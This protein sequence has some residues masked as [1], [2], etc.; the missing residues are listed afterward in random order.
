MSSKNLDVDIT[1]C[2]Y[3][4][5]ECPQ[6]M[7]L[8]A[9]GKLWPVLEKSSHFPM[10]KTLLEEIPEECTTL[11]DIGCGAADL[12]RLI[13]GL[14]YVGADLE[15]IIETVARKVHPHGNYISFDV[16]GDP[17]DCTFV[18]D[19]DVVVMNAFIDV[20]Q[21]P[22]IGLKNILTNAKNYVILHRQEFDSD[23]MTRIE[24]NSS[25]GNGTTYQSIINEQEFDVLLQ[26]LNFK[27][28]KE[29]CVFKTAKSLLLFKEK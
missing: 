14:F 10:L 12:S 3:D 27:V 5:E 26:E 21:Y 22:L 13:N 18:G 11:L 20:L 29:V 23:G 25:Y 28:I 1:T 2:W 19:Y 9:Q 17:K 4:T 16:Y 8:G 15:H 7:I 24:R 6:H